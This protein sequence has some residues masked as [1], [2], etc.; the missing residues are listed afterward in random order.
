[1]LDEGRAAMPL[2]QRVERRQR[3]LDRLGPGLVLPA[4]RAVGRAHECVRGGGDGRI[5]DIELERDGAALTA[6]RDR[7]DDDVAVAPIEELERR[8]EL[9]LRFDC[10]DACAKP[11]K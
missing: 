3:H 8:H 6:N 1:D 11:A 10:H 7:L 9:W 5:V 2:D 4:W